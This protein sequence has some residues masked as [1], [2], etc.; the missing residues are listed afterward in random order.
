MT[1]HPRPFRAVSVSRHNILESSDE[2][3]S[4]H[5]SIPRSRPDSPSRGI[6]R[7]TGIERVT[8][9]RRASVYTNGNFGGPRVHFDTE[10]RNGTPVERG[11]ARHID[12]QVKSGDVYERFR[13]YSRHRVID[14]SSPAPPAQDFERLR[15]RRHSLS[16]GRDAAEEMRID[17]AR[18]L[19]PSPPP[20]RH[21]EEEIRIRHT[22]QL[23]YVRR[24]FRSPPSPEQP[25]YP[26]YKHVA[27]PRHVERTR[28][29]T[30]PPARRRLKVE[31]EDVTDSDSAHSGEVT[32]VRSWRG[33][34]EN[35]RPATFV[36]ERRQVRMIEQ[37]SERGGEFRPLMDRVAARSWRE[38]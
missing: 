15:V 13:E 20:A 29:L 28:S 35:G 11:R 25:P 31:A 1:A 32:E 5:D 8:D 12:E 6:L 3:S 22:S 23:P 17:R 33:L 2:T 24:D 4:T 19:S 14:R 16:P 30:P 7:P 27:R 10:K 37:G 21:F 36:E 9:N 38:V 18:R 26:E 34:D